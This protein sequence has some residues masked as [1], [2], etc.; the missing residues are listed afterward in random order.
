[1]S[2]VPRPAGTFDDVGTSLVESVDALQAVQDG[3]VA[4]TPGRVQPGA[5]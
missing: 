3:S 4:P 1:M 5:C 2:L